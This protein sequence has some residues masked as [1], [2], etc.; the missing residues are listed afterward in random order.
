MTA[1]SGIVPGQ[2]QL[3]DFIERR[4]ETGVELVSVGTLDG[5]EEDGADD[6]N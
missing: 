6:G 3:V 2:S 5:P 1:L 4:Q